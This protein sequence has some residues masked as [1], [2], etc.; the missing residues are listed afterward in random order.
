MQRI[1]CSVPRA[2]G[3]VSA[4]GSGSGSS[5][6]S[7][8]SSGSSSPFND[9]RRTTRH[10]TRGTRPSVGGGSGARSGA[11]SGASGDMSSREVLRD[12]VS[13]EV[14]RT[15]LP[16]AVPLATMEERNEDWRSF[17]AKLVKSQEAMLNPLS[18]LSESSDEEIDVEDQPWAHVIA[19]PEQV[20]MRR[21]VVAWWRLTGLLFRSL[22]L[23]FF[24]AVFRS[25]TTRA[26][27]RF[28]RCRGACCWQIR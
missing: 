8:S 26:L 11:R 25:P 3:I 24:R 2:R 20:R 13:R 17:R 10:S 4:S 22:V 12:L 28:R 15:A 14:A 9:G 21:D 6:H 1:F 19:A 23:W 18:S 7:Q 16:D 27:T 5:S